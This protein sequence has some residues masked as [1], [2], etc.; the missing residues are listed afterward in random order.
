MI[1]FYSDTLP[2]VILEEKKKTSSSITITDNNEYVPVTDL[3]N[4]GSTIKATQEQKQ[5]EQQS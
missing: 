3:L 5:K 1:G 4:I 2:V